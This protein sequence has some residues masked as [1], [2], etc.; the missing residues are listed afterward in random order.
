MSDKTTLGDRMKQYERT[1]QQTLPRRAYT[2]M[3]LDGRAFHSYLKGAAK[4]FDFGFMGSMDLLAIRLCQEIAGARFAYV[5]SDEISILLTDFEHNDTCPWVGGRVDKLTSLSASLAGAYFTRIRGDRPELPTFDCRVWSMADQVEVANYFLWRQRDAVRNSIQMV[6]QNYFT[7]A[8]LFG[9]STD[10][11]QEMLFWEHEVNWNDFPIGA[12]RGRVVQYDETEK[13]FSMGAPH[14][15]AR[16]GMW[17][18]GSIPTLPSF[19]GDDVTEKRG[20]WDV[21]LVYTITKDG[22][23]SESRTAQ[24]L[25]V[26]CSDEETALSIASSRLRGRLISASLISSADELK[27]V[28]GSTAFVS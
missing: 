22:V 23:E 13:W 7:Q 12:K 5:Q 17:L 24:L 10:Q 2:L 1:F 6:G 4:P 18:S 3:R 9:R 8:Q 27:I 26:D 14:F 25:I 21:D 19:T 11:I 16:P 28:T 15:Q 20:D